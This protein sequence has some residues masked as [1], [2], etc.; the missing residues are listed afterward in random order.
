MVAVG[1]EKTHAE[2]LGQGEGFLVVGF[3]L[4]ALRGNVMHSD[5]AEESMNLGLVPALLVN[6]GKL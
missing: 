3:G 2:F 1:L 4:F 5:V 6:L